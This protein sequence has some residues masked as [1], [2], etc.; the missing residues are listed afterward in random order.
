MPLPCG[1]SGQLSHGLLNTLKTH[2]GLEATCDHSSV[3]WQDHC[4]LTD[5]SH[6][7]SLHPRRPDISTALP[8]V[9]FWPREHVSAHVLLG[10]REWL[11]QSTSER[12]LATPPPIEV[13]RAPWNHDDVS[14][15]TG[16]G[17][18]CFCARFGVV[19]ASCC[20][21]RKTFLRV[22]THPLWP[23]AGSAERL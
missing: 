23:R 14:V 9:A 20:Q 10:K 19:W 4:T 15:S 18:T 1:P 22:P 11:F 12:L 13:D 8:A 6:V 21:R 17:M 3:R 7:T 16:S 5:Q 2:M